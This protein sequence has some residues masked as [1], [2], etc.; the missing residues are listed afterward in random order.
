[1]DRGSHSS[2]PGALFEDHALVIRSMSLNGSHQ[3]LVKLSITLGMVAL[4]SALSTVFPWISRVFLLHPRS[5]DR[6][7]SCHAAFFCQLLEGQKETEPGPGTEY[8][9]VLR[10]EI[11]SKE[12]C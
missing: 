1:M 3:F 5:F 8:H 2:E 7:Q 10:N 6:N 11:R 12:H 4:L 9:I